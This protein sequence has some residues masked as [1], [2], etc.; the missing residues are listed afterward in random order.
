MNRK[1]SIS[2]GGICLK[3]NGL[4]FKNLNV[5]IGTGFSPFV[6]KRNPFGFSQN[7]KKYFLRKRP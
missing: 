4:T 3:R 7:L 2:N 5:L 1:S 6:K